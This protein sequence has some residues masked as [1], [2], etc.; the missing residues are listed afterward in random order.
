MNNNNNKLLILIFVNNPGPSL[1]DL[2][3]KTLGLH[4]AV[5]V[6]DGGSTDDSV[7]A[8]RDLDVH[9]MV[10]KP[11]LGKG[12]ALIAGANRAE[13]LGF[14]HI[15]TMD[16]DFGHR[17]EDLLLFKIKIECHPGAIIIGKRNP[18]FQRTFSN[19]W[20]ALQTGA[21]KVDVKCGFRAY[22]LFLFK[23]MDFNETRDSF[24]V[25]VL[26]KSAWAG[27]PLKNVDVA[28][29][30][31]TG[32]GR[33]FIH[34]FREWFSLI[35]LNLKTTLRWLL[36]VGHRQIK[37][38]PD[39]EPL[40][41]LKP[42]KSLGRLADSHMSGTRIAM[43]AGMG[44]FLGTLP[45]IFCHRGAI[46]VVAAF[47]RLNPRVALATAR[48]CC[49]PLMPAISLEAG[50][51]LLHGHFLTQFSLELFTSG[52]VERLQ[53]WF[54]GSIAMAPV[55][56]II[57]AGVTFGAMCIMRRGVKKLGFLD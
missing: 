33:G 2:V 26:V 3:V 7:E 21:G 41:V 34:L 18:V 25:E 47:F 56:G 19:A 1:R 49:L 40:S 50:Y 20:F 11:R 52:W 45:L 6:V 24:E 30:R 54:I 38:D 48:L 22:P 27:I 43:S 36:P 39:A 31:K 53:E 8:L 55:A 46:H 10:N 4:P 32:K 12:A 29:T 15:L 16:P 37:A 14:T 5:M 9:C 42:A 35:F 17:P 51:Y 23:A 28:A 57:T 13:E 44:V